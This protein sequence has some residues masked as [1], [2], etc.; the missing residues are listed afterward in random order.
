MKL[1]FPIVLSLA[2]TAF[3][4][5]PFE[6]ALERGIRYRQTGLS[7]DPPP[8]PRDDYPVATI[9]QDSARFR[10]LFAAVL[11]TY[12]SLT[13]A[14]FLEGLQAGKTYDINTPGKP[15]SCRPC[16]GAGWVRDPSATTPDKKTTCSACRGTGTPIL[17][18]RVC[19]QPRKR[20]LP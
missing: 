1:I 7:L 9:P 18:L 16:T 11:K 14:T 19:W 8:L 13:P 2:V 12:P 15:G 5:D 17:R 4:S 20:G 3:A 6:T 10:V